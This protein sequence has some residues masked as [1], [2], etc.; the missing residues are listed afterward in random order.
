M[1]GGGLLPGTL[2]VV[3]GATGIGKTHLGLRFA[4]HGGEADGRAGLV[5]DMEPER[6]RLRSVLRGAL[7]RVPWP[8]DRV[9]HRLRVQLDNGL[10]AP[11][12]NVDLAPARAQCT[13]ARPFHP[14]GSA[15]GGWPT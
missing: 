5:F 11:K 7:P 14:P 10:A 15:I 2:A 8:Q 3:Y 1:L 4:H 6:E 9:L 13:P 12:R